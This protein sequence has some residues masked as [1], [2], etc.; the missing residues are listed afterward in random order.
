[1]RLKKFCENNKAFILI[2]LFVLMA[3]FLIKHI[4]YVTINPF[5]SRYDLVNPVKMTTFDEGFCYVNNSSEEIIITDLQNRIKCKIKNYDENK[6]F[7]YVDEV[8]IDSNEN[9]Y[10]HDKSFGENGTDVLNERIIKFSPQGKRLDVVYDTGDIDN[11]DYVT[12]DSLKIIDDTIYFCEIKDKEISVI[13]LKNGYEKIF[14]TKYDNKGLKISDTSFYM[15][16]GCISVATTLK[17]GD[18]LRFSGNEYSC[19]YKASEYKTDEFFSIISEVEYGENGQ[20]Y[21]IDV[22]QRRIYKIDANI[23]LFSVVATGRQFSTLNTD[24]F[25]EV[26]IFSGLNISN[27]IISFLSS[28]YIYDDNNDE[29]I[30]YYNMVGISQKGEKLFSNDFVYNSNSV[31]AVAFF[32]DMCLILMVIILIY[33]IRKIFSILKDFKSDNN[34]VIQVAMVITALV[35][36]LAVSYVIFENCNSRLINEMSI[37]LYN[38][39]CLIGEKITDDEF[40]QLNSP[41]SYFTDNYEVIDNKVKD[42]I[43]SDINKDS[44]IYCV[45]YK[46]KND[47][48]CEA[49]REDRLHCAMNPM[50]GKYENSIEEYIYKNN[51]YNFS[52]EFSFSEGT[53]MYIV[54]PIYYENSDEVVLIETGM[55]YSGFVQENSSL[56]KKILMFTFM[57]VIIIML[58]LSEFLCTINAIKVDI[59]SKRDGTVKPPEIIR[60]IAFLFFVVANFSTAFLPIYSLNLYNKEFPI[61]D[62]IAAA[63][64]LSAELVFAAVAAFVCGFIIKKV[65]I[66]AICVAGGIFYVMGGLLSAFSLNIFMLIFA[67]IMCGM[68]S[69][70]LSLALN[71]WAASYDDEESQ[72]KGFININAALLSGL[73][74]GTVIG[75]VVCDIFGIK[76]TFFLSAILAFVL[77][78]VCIILINKIAV[79]DDEEEQTKGTLRDLLTSKV[80]RFFICISIPYLVCTAFLEYFFPIEAENAG[81]TAAHIS[82]AFLISGMISIYVGSSMAEPITAKLGIKKAMILASFIYASALVYL[83]I[84]PNIINYYI[85]VG[86][87]A[88][89]D[90]FGLSA[91]SVYYTSLP[92]VK[93]AGQSKAL[94]VNDTVESVTSAC[95]SLVFGVALALGAE[96]GIF[97]IA[98]VF[99]ILLAI[100]VLF[101]R[102]GKSTEDV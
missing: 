88:I 28:E 84:N 23:N 25:S 59:I 90:S 6:T 10:V 93:R 47:I 55:D 26:P 101:D 49:Y 17:N 89:A 99:T 53:Y 56:Y 38:V 45:I 82:L 94:G 7:N 50:S 33:V 54:V 73:N 4:D 72:N 11:E 20:I 77:V 22:G 78:L 37:K 39:A 98:L 13:S 46:V 64:P 32:T 81:L 30:Y 43:Y 95:G 87:F 97:I 31:K 34:A 52:Y 76:L 48:L 67:N 21:A 79:N 36:T 41:E 61:A 9:I 29:E 92:E 57:A 80:F 86:L 58:I 69:G 91:Q 102:G 42:V 27:G 66:K 63:L 51:K 83:A 5:E 3:A 60:P 24:V 65:G 35:T 44:N 71:T 74:C 85:V 8:A 96:K 15:D 18:I 19:I 16:N 12:I 100:F 75:S 62:E 68:G 1:M 14:N 2:L 40:R 70:S